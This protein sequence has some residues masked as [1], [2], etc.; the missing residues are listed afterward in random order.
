MTR[1]GRASR[2]APDDRRAAIVAATL[3][4]VL[5]DGPAVSTRQ[6]AEAAGV[7]EGTIFR[8]FGDKDALMRAVLEKGFDPQSTLDAL[9]AVDRDLPL[10]AR[11]V[12]VVAVLQDRLRGAFGLIG[13]LGLQQPP[14]PTDEHKRRNEQMNDAF[15]AAIADIVAPDAALLRVD[16][17]EFARVLRLL[18]FSATHPRISDGM[19]MTPDA[20]VAVVLDGMRAP[21]DPANPDDDPAGTPA[22]DHHARTIEV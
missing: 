6:I 16:V 22:V 7:A 9:A 4:L 12:A 2:M 20:I 17:A 15:R 11:L 8:V 13:A 1:S 5:R 18:T 10:R 21:H 14:E 3:P 19:P